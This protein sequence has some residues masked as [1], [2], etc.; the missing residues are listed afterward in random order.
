MD[1]TKKSVMK[2]GAREA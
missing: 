1:P 2:S